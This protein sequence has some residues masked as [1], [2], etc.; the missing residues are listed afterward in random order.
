MIWLCLCCVANMHLAK[1]WQKLF[2]SIPG[3]PRPDTQ[4]RYYPLPRNDV[5]FDPLAGGYKGDMNNYGGYSPSPSY[6][7]DDFLDSR[8]E[9]VPWPQRYPV[10]HTGPN[11]P[12]SGPNMPMGAYH[13]RSM[14]QRMSPSKS[15]VGIYSH[16]C[17]SW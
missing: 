6:T 7:S 17:I 1:T 2:V 4:G 8:R 11:M 12:P 5:H 13:N 16:Q 3:Y 15:G 10:Q 14:S 9:P